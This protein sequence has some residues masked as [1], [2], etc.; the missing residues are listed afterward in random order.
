MEQDAGRG[1]KK[2]HKPNQAA[3][4]DD[5]NLP[6]RGETVPQETQP[7]EEWGER[8]STGKTIAAGGQ[9]D[10]DKEGTSQGEI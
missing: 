5:T 4:R 9:R 8:Q 10:P 1:Q 3:D 2:L 7:A 6:P